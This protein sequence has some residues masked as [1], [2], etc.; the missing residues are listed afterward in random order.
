MLSHCTITCPSIH[1][2]RVEAKVCGPPT[3]FNVCK[4]QAVNLV[5]TYFCVCLFVFFHFLVPTCL[6]LLQLWGPTMDEFLATVG[7]QAMRYAIR[8]GI[9]LTSSYAIGQCSRLLKTVEDKNIL[10]E[11]QSLRKH[12]DCKIKVFL[13]SLDPKCLVILTFFSIDHFSCY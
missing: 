4:D 2:Q 12:L 13:L 9:A 6:G 3:V 7:V 1:L 5:F 10:S 8:S 11:L